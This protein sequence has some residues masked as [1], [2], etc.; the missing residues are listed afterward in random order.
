MT[1][2]LELRVLEVVQ[3]QGPI[4]DEA[5]GDEIA[6][7]LGGDDISYVTTELETKGLLQS[8]QA[9]PPPRWQITDEGRR[10]LANDGGA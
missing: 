3:E 9:S 7:Q 1:S 6:D 4:T 10:T 8:S 5:L 2:E